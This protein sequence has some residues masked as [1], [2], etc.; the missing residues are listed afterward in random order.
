MELPLVWVYTLSDPDTGEVR[1]VGQT[2]NLRDRRNVHLS[3]ARHG[4]QTKVSQWIRELLSV[5][6]N[7]A[8]VGL[9][10]TDEPVARERFWIAYHR[11]QGCDL[12]NQARPQRPGRTRTRI[13]RHPPLI[14]SLQDPVTSATHYIGVTVHFEDRLGTHL[15]RA[16]A[17]KRT[18]PVYVWI[19]S[20]LDAGLKPRLVILE[21]N[22]SEERERWWI[23]HFRSLG[24]PLTN[25]NNGG[26]GW[27]VR[28]QSH[29]D[30]LWASQKERKVSPETRLKLRNAN[31][32]S[33]LSPEQRQE[34]KRLRAE[35]GLSYHR[36]GTMFCVSW[37]CARKVCLG[38]SWGAI[39]GAEAT[40]PPL[41]G[42]PSR[43]SH[44]DTPRR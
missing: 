28:S 6:S 18:D 41:P 8:I 35:Q 38:L 37:A 34:M 30:N 13:G 10:Q 40:Q 26:T 22:G 44:A 5:G 9:E 14:Y 15:A 17:N 36:L 39:E 21:E 29:R 42:I 11:E 33:K 4:S 31:P 27:K 16:K 43:I 3:V 23:G 1:Y 32:S 12:L 2:A 19:R 7:P 24:S 20:L 25:T